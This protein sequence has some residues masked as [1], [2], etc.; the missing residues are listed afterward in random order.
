MPTK[1]WFGHL[2]IYTYWALF[3][4][5]ICVC[6]YLFQLCMDSLLNIPL[7]VKKIGVLN[8]TEN[9]QDKD[10]EYIFKAGIIIYT[11]SYYMH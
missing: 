6:C 5:Y 3:L 10:F 7:Y 11:M 1:A 2:V 8:K 4:W 9:V